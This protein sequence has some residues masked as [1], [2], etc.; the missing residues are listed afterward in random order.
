MF[1]K[2]YYFGPPKSTFFSPAAFTHDCF[3]RNIAL[4]H[5]RRSVGAEIHFKEV[6][7]LRRRFRATGEAETEEWK[8][9]VRRHALPQGKKQIYFLSSADALFGK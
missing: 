6:L 1:L 4:G 7:V 5:E 8:F 3:G 2:N 9:S